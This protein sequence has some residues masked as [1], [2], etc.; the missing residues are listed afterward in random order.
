MGVLI[1][2]SLLR[3][4]ELLESV[5]EKIKFGWS[6]GELKSGGYEPCFERVV[7]S[8]LLDGT[9]ENRSNGDGDGIWPTEF[10]SLI[11]LGSGDACFFDESSG[12]SS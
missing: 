8:D 10:G 6:M 1:S 5:P 7:G 4:C 12:G 3:Y 11:K 9:L 2:S